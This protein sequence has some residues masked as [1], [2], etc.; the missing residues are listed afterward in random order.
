[1][2]YLSKVDMFGSPYI[3]NLKDSGKKYRSP[4][5]GILTLIVYSLSLLYFIYKM[6]LLLDG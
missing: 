4:V 2:N 6:Y 1:M 5:G 3:P